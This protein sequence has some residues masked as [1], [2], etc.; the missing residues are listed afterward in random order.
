[1]PLRETPELV[2][3]VHF[4][5][6]GLDEGVI[7]AA[8]ELDAVVRQDVRVELHVLGDLAALGALEPGLQ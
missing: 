3:L 5:D 2:L 6:V 7:Q 8:C 1:M 4:Q